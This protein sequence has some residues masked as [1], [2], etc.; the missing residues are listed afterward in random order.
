MKIT[1]EH[2]QVKIQTGIR[3][4]Q[5]EIIKIKEPIKVVNI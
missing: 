2:H 5:T 4:E 1:E 3:K